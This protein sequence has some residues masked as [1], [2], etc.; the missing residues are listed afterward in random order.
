MPRGTSS[1][2]APNADTFA[3]GKDK[4]TEEE[5]IE[6]KELAEVKSLTNILPYIDHAIEQLKDGRKSIP[7][8]VYY[9]DAYNTGKKKV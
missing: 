4:F 5:L 9:S 8:T 6:C 2:Y 3:E 7:I 1:S